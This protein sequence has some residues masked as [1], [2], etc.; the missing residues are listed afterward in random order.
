MAESTDVAVEEL[1]KRARRRL[2]G[3]VLLALIAAV[4]LPI[5]LES[6]P[7][8]LGQDVSIQIPPVDGEKF[9]GSRPPGPEAGA[10]GGE[11]RESVT[12]PGAGRDV[13]QGGADSGPAASPAPSEAKSAEP[14][15]VKTDARKGGATEVAKAPSPSPAPA[16]S[17]AYTV[18]VSALS[19]HAKAKE[20][21]DKLRQSGY[22][23]QTSEIATKSGTVMRVRV[24]SYPTREAAQSALDKLRAQGYP[25]IIAEAR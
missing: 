16:D 5:F 25:G 1:R 10:G 20:L 2:V 17:G 4:L 14:P 15:P 3:A 24:G 23:V 22:T 7:K 21:A 13:G 6:D 11:R 12:E 8:P 18:Q 19:D 9:A